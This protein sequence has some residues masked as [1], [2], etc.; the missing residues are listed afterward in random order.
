M[1]GFQ[2]NWSSNELCRH[3]DFIFISFS[4]AGYNLIS[5]FSTNTF[6]WLNFQMDI[7]TPAQQSTQN[8]VKPIKRTSIVFFLGGVDIH[9]WN[10]P[11]FGK[12]SD[13]R[14]WRM[15][16]ANGSWWERCNDC[17][18]T[19][20]MVASS[21]QWWGLV[22][23]FKAGRTDACISG[24]RTDAIER[25]HRNRYCKWIWPQDCPKRP[26]SRNGSFWWL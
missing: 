10:F 2:T 5:R 14:K 15:T 22:K 6:L 1:L 11:S 26:N 20:P 16:N 24:W 17:K 19:A 18:T 21:P 23:N 12:G 9:L 3:S 13:C 8:W 25:K 7:K 4:L